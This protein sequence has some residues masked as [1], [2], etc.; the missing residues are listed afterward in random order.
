M[1]LIIHFFCGGNHQRVNC[2][3]PD[4]D[5][6]RLP[7]PSPVAQEQLG[8]LE[9]AMIQVGWLAAVGAVDAREALGHRLARRPVDDGQVGDGRAGP[10]RLGL[11][12]VLLQRPGLVGQPGHHKVVGH[13]VTLVLDH[14]WTDL[15]RDETE[16][17]K[18]LRS[19]TF[20]FVLSISSRTPERPYILVTDDTREHTL[21]AK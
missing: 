5:E 19:H 20:L 11:R 12:Q 14:G 1:Q 2:S 15:E 4:V 9:A 10:A 7:S 3:S 16:T 6:R 17:R 18:R 13:A 21:N 8:A